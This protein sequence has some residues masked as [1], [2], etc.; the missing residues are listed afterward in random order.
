MRRIA[1][2]AALLAGGCSQKTN[3]IEH[4]DAVAGYT[5]QVP[6]EWAPVV[7]G[8]YPEWPA[9]KTEWIGAVADEHEGIAIG[10]IYTVWRMD[11]KPT[12]KQKKYAETMLAAT[13]ALFADEA[14]EDVMVA[15]GEFAGFP[16]AAFQRELTENLGGGIHGAVRSHPS[17]ISGIAIRTPDAYFVLEYRATKKLFDENLPH[18][19]R[20]RETF[21]LAR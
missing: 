19:Q 16:A 14:P 8:P 4:K 9:R 17:R 20:L 18:F 1:L 5:V 10:A 21:K 3:Y 7:S 6:D 12:A 11:R 2:A 15:A 13:D